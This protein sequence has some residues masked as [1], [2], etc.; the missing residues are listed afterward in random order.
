VEVDLA[1][2]DRA[3]ELLARAA[4][5][6]VAGIGAVPG[7]GSDRVWSAAEDVRAL[8]DAGATALTEELAA[9]TEQIRGARDRWRAQ[10]AGPGR[11][12][13]SGGTL[14]GTPDAGSAD[15]LAELASSS[16]RVGDRRAE[17][18]DVVRRA[19]SALDGQGRTLDAARARLAQVADRLEELAAAHAAVRDVV[20]GYA[21]DLADI[22]D[23]ARRLRAAESE[24]VEEALRYRRI[25]LD[26]DPAVGRPPWQ[27]PPPRRALRDQQAAWALARWQEAVQDHER[28][29]RGWRDLVA[30][31]ESVDRDTAD[32]LDGLPE[33]DGLRPY[34]SG[35]GRGAAMRVTAVLWAGP[36]A[37]VHADDLAALGD[38]TAVRAVWDRLTDVQRQWLV[39]SES[40]ATGNLD[41]IPIAFRAQANRVSMQ[42]EIAR[43]DRVLA[44]E[45]IEF[46]LRTRPGETPLE[47]RRA[48]AEYHHFL[49]STQTVLDRNGVAT[50]V[51]GV[52][53]V[54]FDPA[55]AAIA[56]YHG[57]FDACGD[58]PDWVANVAIHVPGTGTS[59]ANFSDTDARGLDLY[60]RANALVEGQGAGPTAVFAWAGGRLPQ[61]LQAVD[62]GFSRDLGARLRDFAAAVDTHPGR[63]TLTITGH[64]YGGA[65][66]GMAEAAGLRA[67]RVLY[68]SSAGLGNDNTEVADFP[69]TADVPHYALMARDDLIVGH[70]QGADIGSWGHGASPLRD[71]DVVRLETGFLD[72]EKRVP[73]RD[74]ESLGVT[75]SHSGVYTVGSTAFE[76]I[77]QTIVGGR[78]ETFAP[79]V[80]V[81]RPAPSGPGQGRPLI[82]RTVDGIDRDDYVP[83][84]TA[85]R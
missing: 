37:V 21:D 68:V 55:S 10:D 20:G 39:S 53:V 8:L 22:Q 45:G 13:V 44:L 24:A 81:A 76:N 72:D 27:T 36:E 41:G 14:P 71:R 34:L 49:N 66:V 54:V 59:L 5:D 78:V 23:R 67:D 1:A 73:G 84:V 46:Y 52:P 77:V 69:H 30:E 38:A 35:A 56:T 4:H 82:L 19:L 3:V 43:I 18:A 26:V 51:T 58:V 85:S 2:L 32:Q 47:L 57:P 74:I 79:D 80:A 50:M 61:D 16:G 9:A 48:R 62:A 75:A 70:I 12:G 11:P 42:A 63:S 31:R 40:A 29:V 83:H 15:S 64:S 28:V 33:L 60:R 7:C 17:Q 6:E 25:V 65:V